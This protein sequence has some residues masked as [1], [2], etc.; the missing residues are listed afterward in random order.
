MF[1]LSTTLSWLLA[2]VMGLGLGLRRR[3]SLAM[4]TYRAKF[5]KCYSITSKINK[6]NN[7][8]CK[9]KATLPRARS[10][11]QSRPCDYLL[12]VPTF[13]NTR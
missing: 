4:A 5:L 6:R 7:L 9:H 10:A 13:P 2:D 8:A 3:R 1:P 11:L 12:A